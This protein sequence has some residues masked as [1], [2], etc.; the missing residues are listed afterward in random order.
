LK[1]G[2][3]A[4]YELSTPNESEPESL[5]E[6]DPELDPDSDPDPDMSVMVISLDWSWPARF[7]G[8]DAAARRDRRWIAYGSAGVRIGKWKA[9]FIGSATGLGRGAEGQ[10]AAGIAEM[11]IMDR[12]QTGRGHADG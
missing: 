4:E 7:R 1:A 5:I 6:L 8:D 10:Q 9:G 2:L 11:Q 3:S 12:S